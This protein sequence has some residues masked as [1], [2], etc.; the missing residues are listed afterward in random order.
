[1]IEIVKRKNRLLLRYTARGFNDARWIDEALRIEK[2]VTL[3]HTFTFDRQA[4][5]PESDQDELTDETVRTFVLAVTDGDYY[6]VD[7]DIL[8][9]K[10]DLRLWKKMPLSR[11]SD[12]LDHMLDGPVC[13][14]DSVYG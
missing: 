6:K 11:S 14:L 12:G 10:H 2:S 5:V 4:L 8:G 1:M 9:L 13:V 3:R 7:A